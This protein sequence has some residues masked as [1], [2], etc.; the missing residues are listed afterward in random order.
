MN[1]MKRNCI[2]CLNILS[3]TGEQSIKPW[4]KAIYETANFIITP[5]IGAMIEGWI[6]II[7]KRHVPA[8]GALTE[9][10]LSELNELLIKTRHLM[11]LSYGSAVVFEHGP[12]CEGTA[13]GCGIDHAHFHVIPLSTTLAPLV[14]RELRSTVKWEAINDVR[15]LSRIHVRNESYLYILENNGIHGIAA[16]LRDIPS[17]FMRRIIANSL[18][19]PALYDYKKYEFR[20]NTIATFHRLKAAY[21]KEACLVEAK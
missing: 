4:D 1:P 21:N 11:R 14:E 15:D 17:Q 19:I 20:Q 7:S 8:M 13:F 9:K 3:S 6:L 12:A 10:E 16:C 5:S 18:G 2:Y